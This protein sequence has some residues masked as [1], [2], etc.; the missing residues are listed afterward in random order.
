MAQSSSNGKS[1]LLVRSVVEPRFG[2]WGCLRVA[3]SRALQD[4]TGC[5]SLGPMED[6]YPIGHWQPWD[7]I[8]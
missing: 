2:E 1:E 5:S 7:G 8:H 4:M 6:R 3:S